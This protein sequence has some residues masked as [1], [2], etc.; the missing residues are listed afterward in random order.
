MKNQTI[1]IAVKF[2]QVMTWSWWRSYHNNN[3]G[4]NK[5]T[6]DIKKFDGVN[7]WS[8]TKY[9]IVTINNPVNGIN[10]DRRLWNNNEGKGIY[11]SNF[12]R[13]NL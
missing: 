6:N 13:E 11:Y 3:A 7:R 2:I 5:Y 10:A 4:T 1:K 9:D 12:L 8:N